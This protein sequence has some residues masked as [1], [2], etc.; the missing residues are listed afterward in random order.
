MPN[1]TLIKLTDAA[2]KL[3]F[4]IDAAN[5]RAITKNYP[6]NPLETLVIT[7]GIAAGGQSAAYI[8]LETP[9]EAA[10][11]VNAGRAG[12]DLLTS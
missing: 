4:Y 8:V 5:V 3:P 1:T 12:K 7:Y 6:K 9:E 2:S 10:R 11:L